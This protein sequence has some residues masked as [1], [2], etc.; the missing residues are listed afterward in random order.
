MRRA[1]ERAGQ[2]LPELWARDDFFSQAQRKA[3]LRC[4]V[5]RVV[6]QRTAPDQ[7]RARIV[8]KGGD[9][10]MADLPVTVG[11]LARLS[12][13]AAMEKDVV[14]LTRQGYNDA[15]IAEH[16][17][18]QGCRSP[19]HPTVLPST[20]RAIRLRH[21][22]MVKRSQSHP[23]RIA[24]F[25]TLPQVAQ[26]LQVS[27]HWIYDRIN[28]GTIQLSKDPEWQLYLFPD[29]PATLARFRQLREGKVKNL[30]F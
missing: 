14:R 11:A 30:R 26:Q 12:C 21:R 25:L 17:T 19:R 9:T 3:L 7:I 1:L 5:D 13:A 24:G 29:K 6:L 22:L 15:E 23:R 27:P 20:V 28:N 4:L 2:R 16:L 10:T 18:R 8:W